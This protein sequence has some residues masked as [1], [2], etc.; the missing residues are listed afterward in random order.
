MK[1][2]LARTRKARS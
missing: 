2:V 1:I